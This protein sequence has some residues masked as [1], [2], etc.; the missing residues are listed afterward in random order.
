MSKIESSVSK[1]KIVIT[2]GSE[3]AVAWTSALKK[4][5]Y[6]SLELPLLDIVFSAD[7]ETT[8]DVF[9]GL[10]TY[11]WIIFTSPNGVRGFFK[12]FF[13]TFKDLRSIGPARIA[14]VGKT[15][16]QEVEK[17][18]LEVDLIPDVAT[19]EALSEALIATG[20]LDN[21]NV[22][23]VVGNRNNPALIKDLDEGGH[24]LV[25]RFQVYSSEFTNLAKSKEAKEFREKGADALVFASPSA[26]E[27]MIKQS[28]FL[29]LDAKAKKPL[30]VSI[31]SV[32]SAAM[33]KAG[34]P[35]AAECEESSAGG[36]IKTLDRILK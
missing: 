31:G 16:A 33:K 7:K 24:A 20:S 28:E 2:R 27:S 14:C 8:F 36:L 34:L 26:V 22:L 15:T 9:G 29:V 35:I 25:D 30:F 10:G 1:K 17:L 23:V 5:G 13:D 18:H 3:Q 19:A 11:D 4:A 12:V 6:D 21:A 32:T